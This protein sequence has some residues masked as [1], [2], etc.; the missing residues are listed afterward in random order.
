MRKRKGVGRR[1]DGLEGKEIKGK[2]KGKEEE[3]EG[4]EETNNGPSRGLLSSWQ[5]CNN[6]LKSYERGKYLFLKLTHATVDK[7]TA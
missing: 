2:R 3:E 1:K 6:M 7:N 5:Q 4:A